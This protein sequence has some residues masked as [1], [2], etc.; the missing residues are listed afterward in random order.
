MSLFTMIFLIVTVVMATEI[1]KHVA[2][3][4]PSNEAKKLMNDLEERLD[5]IERR[6]TNVETIVT[7]KDYQLDQEFESL[8]R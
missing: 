3:R 8:K 7:G 2:P 6:L 5:R 4:R 1:V